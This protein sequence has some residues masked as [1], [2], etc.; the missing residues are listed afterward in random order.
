MEHGLEFEYSESELR[1]L[2]QL[3]L[4]DEINPIEKLNASKQNSR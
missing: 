3:L 1:V 4:D 2:V